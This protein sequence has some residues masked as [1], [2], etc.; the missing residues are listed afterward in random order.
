MREDK[1]GGFNERLSSQAEARRALL[2]KFKPKPTVQAEILET[3]AQR[4]AREIEEVRAKRAADKEA[5]R[6]KAEA[7][8]EAA[9]LALANNEEAQLELKRQDRKDR[10]AQAKAEARAKREAKSA[11]RRS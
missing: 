9:R 6:L 11:Q 10:K 3:R 5:A 8:K 4:K 1:I 2:E 7:D